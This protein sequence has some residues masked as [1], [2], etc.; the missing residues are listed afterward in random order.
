MNKI[1]L[2][3]II[4]EIVQGEFEVDPRGGG[5]QASQATQGMWH[6]DKGAMYREDNPKGEY[7]WHIKSKETEEPPE[8]KQT[9][10][11]FPGADSEYKAP[12]GESS[13]DVSTIANSID[14]SATETNSE[15]EI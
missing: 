7:L 3:N 4:R 15:D 10:K 1:N 9:P 5:Q 6:S 13:T 11:N 14:T 2:K 12:A 8:S